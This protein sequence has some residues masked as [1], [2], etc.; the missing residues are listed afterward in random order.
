MSSGAA[1]SKTGSDATLL[2]GRM[3]S[4]VELI[5][6][7]KKS[8]KIIK[9][10]LGWAVLYNATT[11]PLAVSGNIPPWLAAIGMSISSLVAVVNALRLNAHNTEK[12]PVL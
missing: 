2:N 7:S 1:L 8:R 3:C 6:L 10:N 11:I 5:Q 12:K 4:L 9:Q